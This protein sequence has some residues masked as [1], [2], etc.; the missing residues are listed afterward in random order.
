[1]PLVA[2]LAVLPACSGAAPPEASAPPSPRPEP[3]RI[4][5][6]KPRTDELANAKVYDEAGNAG[7]CAP[8]LGSCPPLPA[9]SPFLDQCRLA[10]FQVRQ[11][12]C[13]ARCSGDAAAVNRHYDE[14]GNARACAPSKPECT[15]PQA[16]AAFQD[17]CSERSYRLDVCG[18]EWLCSG[19]PRK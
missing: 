4:V 6:A 17:A 9:A 8:P 16:S 13:E 11:C 1:M 15:P 2:A 5:S 18:C 12:G 7:P 14:S 10:G 3:A 19:N